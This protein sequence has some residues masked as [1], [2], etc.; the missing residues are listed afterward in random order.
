MPTVV[1]IPVGRAHRTAEVPELEP[2]LKAHRNG[3]A[4]AFSFDEI[5]GGDRAAA[6]AN[7][8]RTRIDKLDVGK[9]RYAT[10]AQEATVVFWIT[11]L[12]QAN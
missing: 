12:E 5:G 9:L 6:L 3:K 10:D 11:P 1:E 7:R 2:I 4:V 8:L